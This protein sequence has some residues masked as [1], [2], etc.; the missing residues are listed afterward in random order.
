MASLRKQKQALEK[1]RTKAPATNAST[2]STSASIEPRRSIWPTTPDLRRWLLRQADEMI[3]AITG[4]RWRTFAL[5][6]QPD[7][8][9]LSGCS[10]RA[11]CHDCADR[12][13][14]EAEQRPALATTKAPV[15]RRLEAPGSRDDAQ[16]GNVAKIFDK[17]SSTAS[18]PR[19]GTRVVDGASFR[20]GRQ[21][22]QVKL[23]PLVA[24]R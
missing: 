5:M 15:G 1:S 3:L 18:G 11:G 16:A 9:S 7:P 6:D 12:P 17:L 2:R 10:T 23:A 24:A 19:T 13:C 8:P 20:P 4:P 22:G 14:V 21:G